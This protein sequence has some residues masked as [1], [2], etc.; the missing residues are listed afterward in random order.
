[1][2]TF[3]I[4]SLLILL[5]FYA[6]AGNYKVAQERFNASKTENLRQLEGLTDWLQ[7][8]QFRIFLPPQPVDAFINGI[9]NDLGKT[10]EVRGRGELKAEDSLYENDTI[11]AIFRFIDLDFIFTVVLSLCAI[12]FAYDSINGEKERGTLRLTFSY[13]VPKDIYISGK[14]IGAC[15]A[16]L[17]PLLIPILIGALMLPLLGVPLDFN[18]A[19]KLALVIFAGLLL[20]GTFITLSVMVSSLTQRTSTSFL[21]LLVIWILAVLIIPRISVITAGS[22]VSVPAV[23]EINSQKSRLQAQLWNEDRKAVNAYKPEMNKGMQEA[24]TAFN[25][26]MQQR[27][28][29]RDKKLQDLSNRLNE[30]RANKQSS[31][32]KLAFTMARLSPTALFSLASQ[33]A[34]GTS[35]NLEEN[36]KK[37]ALLYRDTYK[38]FLKE[39][40]GMN[41]G[42]F[43]IFRRI[44]DGQAKPKPINVHEI[45]EFIYKSASV[46]EN[47]SKALPDLTLLA[48]FNLAFFA[49]SFFSFRKYD[50]R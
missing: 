7:V 34:A 33:K 32:E 50:P 12:L 44:E 29:E 16:L 21:M 11:F 20:T 36:F 38:K 35:I 14:I 13:A 48:I 10:I 26:F 18:E 17:L 9:S 15:L 41:A 45:P 8:R 49:G 28:D 27:A 5:S 30:D 39:K 6:G 4:C 2:V 1:A 3:G 46:S 25:K 24:M 19:G 37:S 22:L 31:M 23:D 43:M 40:T 47:L 42:G